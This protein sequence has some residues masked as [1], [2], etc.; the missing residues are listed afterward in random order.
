MGAGATNSLDGEMPPKT[1]RHEQ[2]PRAEQSNRQTLSNNPL[3][4]GNDEPL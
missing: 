4:R 2:P 3:S 1:S